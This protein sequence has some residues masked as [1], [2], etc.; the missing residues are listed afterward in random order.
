MMKPPAF[1]QAMLDGAAAAD[2][3]LD[4]EKLQA[5]LAEAK[6]DLNIANEKDVKALVRT[7]GQVSCRAC[8]WL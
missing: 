6:K 7:L 5:A 4:A 8:C 3:S 1:V 2:G